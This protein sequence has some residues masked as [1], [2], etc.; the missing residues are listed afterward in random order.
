MTEERKKEI[1]LEARHLVSQMTIEEKIFQLMDK[2]PHIKR[3]NIPSYTW[4]NEALHGVARAGVATVF[5]QA[6][7][8]AATFNTSLIEKIAYVIST[9]GR[10]KYHEFFKRGDTG[11][12]KGLTF[13]SPNINIFRDPRW[14]RGHETYGEDPYLTSKMGVSYVV[15]L[16]GNDPRYL[17]AAACVKHYAVH[18]GPEATRHEFD[19]IVGKQDLYETYLPAFEECVKEAKVEAVMGAYNRVNGDVCCGSK[20]LL[21]TILRK[22]WGFEGHVVSDCGAIADFHTTHNVTKTPDE[23]AALALKSGCDLNCGSMYA[24]LITAFHD[25]LISQEDIDRAAIRLIKTRIKLGI[26]GENSDNPYDK[27][28]YEMND[29]SK[30]LNLEAS[31]QSLVL[32][33]NNG[34][35]PL[36]K[37]KIANIGV[38]GPNASSIEVLRGNYAGTSSVYHTVLAGMQSFADDGLKIRYAEGCDIIKS[39]VEPCAEENDRLSEARLVC[40]I[41]DVVILCLGLSPQLE[42]E[43]GD[44]FN[45]DGSGDKPDLELPATQKKLL[46]TVSQS[47]KPF[48]LVNISGSALVIDKESPDAIIQAFYPGALGG[49][50]VAE[51]IFGKFNPSGKLPVTFYQTTKELPDYSD[52]SMSGRTYR[53]M[54]NAPLYAFGYGL[55]YSD[56]K[57]KILDCDEKIQPSDNLTVHFQIKNDSDIDGYEVAQLYVEFCGRSKGMPFKSL[58]G[59]KKSWIKRH[60]TVTESFIL[61]PKEF[62]LIDEAGDRVVFP[63][64]YKIY[65]GGCSPNEKTL[66][67]EVVIDGEKIIL[68]KG[69]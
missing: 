60:E 66:Y 1:D 29:C 3:L 63:G 39:Q 43:Q 36:D 33:K 5:P 28:N 35:L 41:S 47:G 53:Y 69:V 61:S 34:L 68:D 48:I 38:I 30:E 46:E 4:W 18:S 2:A 25:G 27:I 23:S 57:Y 8:L 64:R 31:R 40:D 13:W 44:A 45:G 32:L 9:E 62:S 24:H 37:Q 26:I 42:G 54:E 65:M 52:Y 12:Y 22:K 10:A 51:L 21:D 55:S 50:A 19:A 67:K 6:I 58:K 20:Y 14:G 17:K 16:Q 56:F 49:L 15:G 59:F 7:G 11:A